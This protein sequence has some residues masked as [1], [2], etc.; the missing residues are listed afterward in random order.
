[1]GTPIS[2]TIVH[3]DGTTQRCERVEAALARAGDGRI[4]LHYAYASAALPPPADGPFDMWRYTRLLPIDRDAVTYPL[5]VGGTPLV[6]APA[7]RA[8]TRMPGLWLKDETRGPTGS[9]KDR[10][11]ALVLQHAM[12]ERIETVSCASTGNVAVSL[13]VGAAVAG[14]RAVVFV[15][16]GVDRGKLS[17]MLA[18]GAMA[19]VVTDGYA[20]AFRLSREA[21][22]TFG[23]YD[24]NTGVNPL[25]FEAKKT[26][27]FEIWEQLGRHVP[28]AVVSPVGDGVTLS[29]LAKGFRELVA[30]GVAARVPRLIGVQAEGCQPIAHAWETGTPPEPADAATLADGIAVGWPVNAAMALRDVRESDGGFV[31]VPDDTIVAAVGTLATKAG[32]LAEPAGAAAAAGLSRAVARGLA[33]RDETVVVLVTGSALKTP[34]FLRPAASPVEVRADIRELRRVLRGAALVGCD[35]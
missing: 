26:V 17:V 35:D 12:H 9:N 27:A 13:A 7:L 28:D 14:K 21:A 10:A 19:I 24:R 4:E 5:A 15:P 2:A 25:T 6:A 34:R 1:M 33:R 30:C 23:W 3:D 29:A 22:K 16:A 11:T 32:I 31:A 18:A 20:G 8:G